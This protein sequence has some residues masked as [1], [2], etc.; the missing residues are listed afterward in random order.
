MRRHAA[1]GVLLLAIVGRCAG[2]VL[3][4]PL[5][6]S[7]RMLVEVFPPSSAFRLSAWPV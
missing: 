3:A 4:V 5:G 1:V 2:L 7:Q 6:L